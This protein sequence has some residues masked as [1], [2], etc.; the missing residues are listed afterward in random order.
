MKRKHDALDSSDEREKKRKLEH[1]NP[2]SGV[3]DKVEPDDGVALA[4]RG[5]A[6][7]NQGEFDLALAYFNAALA[8]NPDDGFALAHRGRVY[9]LQNQFDLALVDFNAALKNQQDCLALEYR[10]EVYCIQNELD[11][12]LNDFKALL[13]MDPHNGVALLNSGLI[14]SADA[15]S[16][17]HSLPYFSEALNYHPDRGFILAHRGNAYRR[18]GEIALAL[19][20]LHAAL[21]IKPNDV[22]ALTERGIAYRMQKE[23]LLALEDFNAALHLKPN[24]GLA[25]EER[26]Q[27]YHMLGRLDLALANFDVALQIDPK[28]VW[29]LFWRGEIYKAQGQLDRAIADCNAILQINEDISIAGL[30]TEFDND[31]EALLLR[32]MCYNSQ[33]HLGL[34]LD[35]LD[36]VLEVNSEDGV[37]LAYRGEVYRQLGNYE[38]ALK[39]FVRAE[40]HAPENRINLEFKRQL[41]LDQNDK[42]EA[43]K[44]EH[45]LVT[46]KPYSYGNGTFPT[47]SSLA[48]LGLFKAMI[49]TQKKHAVIMADN[50]INADTLEAFESVSKKTVP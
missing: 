12:A 50:D 14:Y 17:Y 1:N 37:A 25:I 13:R 2:E 39:D 38:L 8:I 40:K 20:D 41:Y 46:E 7:R 21:E 22:Y 33:G 47:L 27:V 34:A 4:Q 19:A 5:L 49:D 32:A 9:F 28:R 44:I 18:R 23:L 30:E 11:L 24:N 26:G 36:D 35:D 10:G 48:K 6:Y 3:F 43:I 42:A 29:A 15:Y 45:Q 31:V 16:V